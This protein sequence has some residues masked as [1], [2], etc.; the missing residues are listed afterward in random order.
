MT[1][2]LKTLQQY[3]DLITEY[4][5][6]LKNKYD[7]SKA[8]VQSYSDALGVIETLQAR[9]NLTREENASATDAAAKAHEA[10][11]KEQIGKL[12][13]DQEEA[14]SKLQDKLTSE[15]KAER[16]T[17]LQALR[18]T[19]ER[20]HKEADSEIKTAHEAEI[21]AAKVATEKKAKA[22]QEMEAEIV[23]KFKQLT[24]TGAAKKLEDF[25]NICVCH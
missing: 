19:L 21:A 24:D 3:D 9:I 11:L 18:E 13:K 6:K 22:D 25:I 14:I 5:E 1:N 16:E 4:I 10:A 8:Y 15:N 7:V 12:E 23:A 2:C 20:A 17:A